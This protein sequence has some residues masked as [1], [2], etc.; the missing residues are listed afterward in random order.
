M[1][2]R[3]GRRELQTDAGG[4]RQ[5]VRCRPPADGRKPP[6]SRSRFAISSP[7]RFDLVFLRR[8]DAEEVFDEIVP[9]APDHVGLVTEAVR[10]IRQQ[11][12]IEILV[13]G[14]QRVHDKQ[15]VAGRDVVVHGAVSKQQ[16][17][18]EIPGVGLVGFV[19][20]VVAVASA[21][22]Q[23]LVALARSEEH[24]SE[25]QSRRDLVCRLLLEKKKK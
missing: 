14:D 15:G 1:Q 16:L 25:L 10:A 3:E 6:A 2:L 24:T 17:S 12:Q 5:S 22:Q 23:A 4:W 20:I 9:A 7:P 13:G 21:G 18:L 19:C 8:L 11:Y